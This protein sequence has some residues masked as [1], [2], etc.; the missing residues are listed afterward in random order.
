MNGPIQPQLESIV[1]LCQNAF[2]GDE[3]KKA[4]IEKAFLNSQKEWLSGILKVIDLCIDEVDHP[5]TKPSRKVES[6]T[7]TTRATPAAKRAT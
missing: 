1:E 7:V 6:V 3:R 4:L 5:P 2:R